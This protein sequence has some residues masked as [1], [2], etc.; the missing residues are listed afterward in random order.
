MLISGLVISTAA[1][2]ASPACGPRNQLLGE[3]AKKYHEAPVALGLDNSGAL[4]VV[5]TSDDGATWTILANRPNG[6]S[7]LVASGEEW[8]PLK[9]PAN[10]VSA[11]DRDA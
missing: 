10:S 9:P 2:A 4:I 6:T 7:C 11:H 1:D 3:L 8:Q 5:L